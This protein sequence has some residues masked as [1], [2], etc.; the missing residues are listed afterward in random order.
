MCLEEDLNYMDE[1]CTTKSTSW[2][3]GG[4]QEGG[5]TS[6]EEAEKSK[7]MLTFSQPAGF[8]DFLETSQSREKR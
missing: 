6:R 5:I 4:G 3:Y 8:K 7:C 1:W 2:H